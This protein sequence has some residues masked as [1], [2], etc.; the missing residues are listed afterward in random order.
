MRLWNNRSHGQHGIGSLRQERIGRPG[1]AAV[2][3]FLL[4]LAPRPAS[5]YNAGDKAL[6]GLANMMAGVMVFPGEIHKNWIE[7]GPA[8]GL[9]VGVALGV[10]MIPVRELV[11]VIEFL[12][13]PA[14][15][16]QSRF[17]PLLRPDY[18]WDYFQR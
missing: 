14:P 4:L 11:G 12:T 2:L 7:K 15:W 1:I 9:T 3:L 6:R 5:A 13:C 16:P 18:P 10:G 8:A 17:E